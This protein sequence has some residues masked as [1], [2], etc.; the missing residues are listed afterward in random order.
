MTKTEIEDLLY[1]W[2]Y[3]ELGVTTIFVRPNAPR[4]TGD[5]VSINV[6]SILPV[7]EPDSVRTLNYQTDEVTI[8]RGTLSEVSVS[9]NVYRDGSFEYGQQLYDSLNKTTVIEALFAGGL[10][11]HNHSDLRDAPEIVDAM[12]EERAQFDIKFYCRYTS[13]ET[14]ETIRNI[15]FTNEI[16]DSE[17]TTDVEYNKQFSF[18]DDDL[19]LGFGL[20]SDS[21]VGGRFDSLFI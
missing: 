17:V 14:I 21:S 10:G 18:Y 15:E 8:T 3:G 19:G 1:T 12:W 4:P 5:Y 6:R 2:I 7:G 16:D 20:Y 9:I 13:N 11:L